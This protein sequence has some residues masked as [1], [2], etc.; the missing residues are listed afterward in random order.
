M[1]NQLWFGF[2]DIS[3]SFDRENDSNVP[4]VCKVDLAAVTVRCKVAVTSSDCGIAL[5]F[6]IQSVSTGE[7]CRGYIA[8]CFFGDSFLFVLQIDE[9]LLNGG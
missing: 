6:R 2:G 7:D 4:Q 1:W 3:W 9:M 5:I 8:L